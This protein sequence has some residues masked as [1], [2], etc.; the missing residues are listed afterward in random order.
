[1]NDAKAVRAKSANGETMHRILNWNKQE[2]ACVIP[3]L[4]F[5]NLDKTKGVEL[6]IH[7]WWE[8]ANLRIK[9]MQLM[10]DSTKLFFINPKVKY[11][12]NIPG[13]HP[14]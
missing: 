3:T 7:Q 6:F 8:I 14:G 12:T 9:K 13:L 5:Q 2:A 10:G 4:A 11:K 1:M